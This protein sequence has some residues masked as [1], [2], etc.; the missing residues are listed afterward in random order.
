MAKK[1]NIP[2][3]QAG[4]KTL[5]GAV[6]LTALE[7]SAVWELEKAAEEKSPVVVACSGGV[8]SLAALLLVWAHFPELRGRL[9]VAHFNHRTRPE[10]VAEEKFV[11]AVATSLGEKFSGGIRIGEE[12]SS[13]LSE[14]DLRQARLDFLRAT[15]VTAQSKILVQ[16]HQAEDVAETL[17]MRL[18]RGSG[19]AGLAAPRPV[20][21]FSSGEIFVRPLLSVRKEILQEAMRA[22]GLPWCEDGSNARP[23]FLRNRIRQTVFPAWQVA[24]GESVLDGALRSRR[25]L[26][27]DDAALES[28]VDLLWEKI[29]EENGAY[30]WA[31]LHGL[32]VAVQRRALWR[33]FLRHAVSLS[34]EAVEILLVA[35]AAAQPGRW[36]AG[37]N[38][39]LVFDGKVL[40]WAAEEI[41]TGNGS[42]VL[43]PGGALAWP[44][45]GWLCC[46]EGN[47]LDAVTWATLV[48]GEISPEQQVFLCQTAVREKMTVRFWRA[49][50]AYQP[51]GAPGR[52][53][54]SDLFIDK[55]IPETE[56]CFRPVVCDA[57]GILWVPGLP[58]AER[59]RLCSR[60]DA[61]L[62]LT[63]TRSPL[64][65][66]VSK[67]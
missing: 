25:L 37:G 41:F 23:D 52:R 21:R 16:G 35:L 29:A 66:P 67:K 57:D 18:G 59:A 19:T 13:A 38:G 22:A 45:G 55:K 34:A 4:A 43:V 64:I 28:W 56:R 3:W 60:T 2:D 11:A 54:L 40:H 46:A 6:P 50:D 36:S 42:G 61:A 15:L 10:C 5:A 58:P 26:A 24:Q 47:P 17:L 20:Q 31:V 39:W 62:R 30:C 27:E 8:D 51:L 12:I 33:I 32:P 44:D 48:A 14:A 9:T 49:G 53:K 7:E 1:E 65:F 63:W